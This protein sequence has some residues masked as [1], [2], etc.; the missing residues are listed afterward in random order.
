MNTIW[1]LVLTTSETYTAIISDDFSKLIGEIIDNVI[2]MKLIFWN[3]KYYFS[4]FFLS[5]KII[6]RQHDHNVYNIY[7]FFLLLW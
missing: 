2:E 5:K 4:I 6:Q 7:A 1:S 3:K